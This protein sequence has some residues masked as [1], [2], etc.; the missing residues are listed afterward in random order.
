MRNFL[1]HLFLLLLVT[2]E[3]FCARNSEG[4]WFQLDD[5]KKMPISS[6]NLSNVADLI[7]SFHDLPAHQRPS[8]W[9]K[10]LAEIGEIL[11]PLYEERKLELLQFLSKQ[12]KFKIPFYFVS[13]L[14]K[15][16]DH[17]HEDAICYNAAYRHVV[18]LVEDLL[19]VIYTNKRDWDQT[20]E[21]LSLFIEILTPIY[22]FYQGPK[23]SP[24]IRV[25]H[26]TVRI[27]MPP[28]CA[29]ILRLREIVTSM[30]FDEKRGIFDETLLRHCVSTLLRDPYGHINPA[31]DH[32]Y[33]LIIFC[34]NQYYG[35]V[36]LHS[37]PP[38]VLSVIM[39]PPFFKIFLIYSVELCHIAFYELTFGQYKEFYDA[40]INL[41]FTKS[42][43]ELDEWKKDAKNKL[44]NWE[45]TQIL[46]QVRKEDVDEWFKTYWRITYPIQS[47]FKDKH[48]I[49]DFSQ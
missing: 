23:F 31:S 17:Y 32:Y 39:Y 38:I 33:R 10:S 45:K 30:K 36:A 1:F 2:F 18:S 48:Y 47:E 9:G 44:S 15:D 46:V 42:S 3:I 16:Y 49:R 27:E 5:L 22:Q 12:D 37:V 25:D 4:E 24:F 20:V 7:I 6:I 21:Y 35:R 8:S 29:Y 14:N 28:V 41:S 34:L 13:I 40:L 43:I 11:G 26:E 19:S